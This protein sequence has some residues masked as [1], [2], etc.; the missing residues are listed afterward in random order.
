M[1]FLK[2]LVTFG[3][4]GRIERKLEEFE[5]L[6]D[7]YESLYSRMEAKREE[8]NRTLQRVI[9]TKVHAVKS[10]RKIQKISK[11]IKDRDRDFIYRSIGNEY[12]TVDFHHIDET[13]SAGQIA[14][15]ATKGLSA[16][17]GTALGAW[18]LVSTFGTA[19][20]GAAIVGLSGAA[21][22]NATLAW[23]GG[24][25]L[26]AGGGGAMA[27][28]AVLGGIVAIPALAIFGVFNHLSANK[29][30]AEIEREM[31]KILRYIDEMEANLLKLELIEERSEELITAIDKAREVFEHEL[32]R[33]LR[34]LNRIPVLS[35]LIRWT[36]KKLLRLNYYSQA[37]VAKIGY[38]GGIATDFAVL[39]DTPVFED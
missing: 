1:S 8:V 11:N 33:T 28:T 20:T 23:F 38:I 26:A 18:A 2:N 12:E 6:K 36:R 4:H 29:K 32:N 31:N 17:V 9:K 16:G 19:S 13:I 10:L 22:T 7:Q 35:R 21:A 15:S 39:I 37:D 34:E 14:M 30:I 27:G 5:D 25:A 24:G 3:A